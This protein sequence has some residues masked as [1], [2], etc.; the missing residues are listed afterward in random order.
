VTATNTA[1]PLEVTIRNTGTAALNVSSIGF[2][3]P[4]DSSFV[5][6]LSGGTKPCASASPTIAA[7]DSCTVQVTFQPSAD[8]TFNSTL[9]I[10]SNDRI[11]PVFG[12]PIAGVREPVTAWTVRINQIDDASTLC[13]MATAYVSVVDQSGFPVMLSPLGL[14]SFTVTQ[15]SPANAAAVTSVDF[16]ENVT[17]PVAIAAA[18]D[19]SGSLTDQPVAFSDMKSGFSTF[20][21]S[22]RANDL[23]AVINFDDAVE[24]VQDWTNNK[25]ALQ[26]A[27]VAP[28]DRG[29]NTKLF[30][31]TQLSVNEASTQ[32]A[33]NL[34]R[35]VIVAT[36][37]QDQ[38]PTAPYS[39][40]T[41]AEVIINA[42]AKRVP[43]YTVGVG[44]GINRSV[45]SNMATSTGG[46]F[47]EA[48][49]SQNLATIYQQL[50]SLLFSK[51]YVVK[52]NRISGAPG[53]V[54]IGAAPPAG[55]T[56]TPDSRTMT[57]CP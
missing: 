18:L 51:Q 30:D 15:G 6:N 4:A 8:R 9:Q 20:F 47:F 13:P 19:H 10:N 3:A 50:A 26:A 22:I 44:A 57:P 53:S 35:A 56:S 52:F 24:K 36:D 42:V 33:V 7:S 14:G 31:A 49:T 27:A 11:A 5:L 37:G 34:R 16:I 28:W 48:T 55:V 41:Q 17:Y 54:S 29:R 1:A 21:G 23:G 38:G 32:S 43:I 40:A 25:A 12:L 45:L 39:T 2:Q 46:L